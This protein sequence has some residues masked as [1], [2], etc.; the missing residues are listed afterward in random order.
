ME[1]TKVKINLKSGE[2]EFEGSQEFVQEQM[3]NL[4]SI[5]SIISSRKPSSVNN[6][7]VISEEDEDFEDEA[8]DDEGD[9]NSP[10]SKADLSVPESFGEWM[11]KFKEGTKG[12]DKALI[13]AYYVQQ[14]APKNDFKTIEVNNSLKD[15]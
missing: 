7:S 12:I 11:H 13:T 10:P 1:T 5:L 15:H 6:S 14:Q 2:I 4:G 8:I 3:D 9:A